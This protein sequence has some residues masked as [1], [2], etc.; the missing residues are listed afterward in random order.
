MLTS[1]E[2]PVESEAE[3]SA[4]DDGRPTLLCFSH[5]RWDFVWQRPQQIFSRLA[6]EHHVLF[7]EEPLHEPGEPGL[8]IV[9]AQPGVERPYRPP[10]AW[11]R[12]LFARRPRNGG[13]RLRIRHASPALQDFVK[14]L[15][16][17][18]PLPPLLSRADELR[19]NHRY[20]A[21][22][23]A[24]LRRF[25]PFDIGA[26]LGEETPRTEVT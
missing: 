26:W 10:A 23:L 7:V 1:V 2:V 16:A 17:L 5:L 20:F 8:R 13:T 18:R 3:H 21:D 15:E 25:V 14:R 12:R 6:R 9:E 4:P 22:D 24:K 11:L 19:I